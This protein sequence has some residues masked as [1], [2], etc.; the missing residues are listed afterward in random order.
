MM[1]ALLT[2]ISRCPCHAMASTI[3]RCTASRSPRSAA[4]AWTFAPSVVKSRVIVARLA[5]SRPLTITSAPA[6]A[7]ARAIALPSP[8]EEPVTSATFPRR[9]NFCSRK[10]VAAFGEVAD[11]GGSGESAE[12]GEGMLLQFRERD[13]VHVGEDLV[14]AAHGP[15]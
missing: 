6:W 14:V 13:L 5:A 4:S 2:R 8:R 10:P 12:A 9:P 15:D 7:S 3:K 11:F 1:P